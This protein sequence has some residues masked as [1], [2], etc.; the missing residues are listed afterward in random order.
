MFPAYVHR[1][2]GSFQTTPELLRNLLVRPFLAG[3][4]AEFWRLWNPFVGYWLCLYCYRPLRRFLPRA[5]AAL[6]T[7]AVSGFIVHDL[8][9]TLIKRRPAVLSTLWFLLMGAGALASEALKMNMSSWPAGVRGLLRIGC[10]WVCLL[11]AKELRAWMLASGVTGR[12]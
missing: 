10:R 5:I 4:F 9:T 3:S 12:F 8:A 7:F 1:R 11:A 2:L 6:M